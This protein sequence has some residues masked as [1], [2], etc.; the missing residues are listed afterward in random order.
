MP[1]SIVRQ[2][3]DRNSGVLFFPLSL[4][5]CACSGGERNSPSLTSPCWREPS[6]ERGHCTLFTCHHNP[7]R[8]G[9]V[10]RPEDWRWPSYNEYAGTSANESV[11]RRVVRATNL[12]FRALL[13][14]MVYIPG[15][16][17][18]IVRQKAK[19]FA[20]GRS[21][22]VR[23]PAAFRFD[24]KEVFIDRNPRTGDVILSRKPA[25]W[26]EVFAAL[27]RAGVP[28]D[29]LADRDRS[30]PQERETV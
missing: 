5:P 11:S 6:T 27:D 30:L 29:L 24:T 20:N 7:V 8:A 21:Q 25:N 26:S 3:T 2:P 13:Y 14:I 18:L 22:A 4:S 9:L 12:T 1:Y 23:L 16:E 17:G 10:R 28:E 15:E 19:V